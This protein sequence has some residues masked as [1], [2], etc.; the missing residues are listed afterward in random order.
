MEKESSNQG[1]NFLLI[2]IIAILIFGS[3][4]VVGFFTTLFWIIAG[5]AVVIGIIWIIFQ[6]PS[7]VKEGIE[8]QKIAY[9][10]HPI[11]II[12]S[13]IVIAVAIFIWLLSREG[14][15]SSRT[16]N[17]ENLLQ[18][19][20]SIDY[21]SLRGYAFPEVNR[22]AFTE[23]CIKEA[24]SELAGVSRS[25]CL[26]L[27]NYLELNYSFK[28]FLNVEQEYLRTG[29]FPPPFTAAVNSCVDN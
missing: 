28:E 21:Q 17:P 23:S 15:H 3:G 4:A 27:L 24:G 18:Q 11:G 1:T 5:I 10:K 22:S 16:N 12:L 26:C 29:E 19:T 14:T 7:V 8:E 2:L 20:N 6:I 25:Y 13:L 9:K